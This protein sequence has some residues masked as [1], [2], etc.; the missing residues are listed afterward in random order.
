MFLPDMGAYLYSGQKRGLFLCFLHPKGDTAGGAGTCQRV[1]FHTD[2][3][4]V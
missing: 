4:V 2:G 3:C 1:S